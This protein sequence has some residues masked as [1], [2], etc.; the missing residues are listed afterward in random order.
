MTKKTIK[1]QPKKLL[2]IVPIAALIYFAIN[3]TFEQLV[4]NISDSHPGT[5]FWKS[6]KNPA[7]N[8]FVYFYF[9]HELLPKNFKI[10]SKKLVCVEGD[11]LQINDQ[12]ITCNEK[13][14]LIRRNQKTGSGK[15][16]NQ[17]YYDGLVPKGKA[18]VWGKNLE[19]F[20]SRYW[21][22]IAYKKLRIMELIL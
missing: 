17:F 8:D 21:G 12:F 14:Y 6:N 7:K 22:F 11:K 9:R 4:I 15:L 16:I 18:I 20:D 13:K 2:Y 10:L 3:A 5:I 19:S 1:I